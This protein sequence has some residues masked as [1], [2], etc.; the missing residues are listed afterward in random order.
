MC[1]FHFRLNILFTLHDNPQQVFLKI[2]PQ[3]AWWIVH[4]HSQ[5]H[6]VTLQTATRT[7]NVVWNFK[8]RQKC[9]N[10]TTINSNR[11]VENFIRPYQNVFSDY[12]A[13]KNDPADKKMARGY[14]KIYK[15]CYCMYWAVVNVHLGTFIFCIYYMPCLCYR[16]N[17]N[18]YI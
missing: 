16:L 12:F 5:D 17:Y 18:M 2:K 11:S 8:C 14:Y 15:Q 1:W 10:E 9:W 13:L 4:N 6:S 3:E 7:W